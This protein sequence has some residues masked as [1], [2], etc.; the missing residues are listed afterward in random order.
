MHYKGKAAGYDTTV[1][2]FL[3]RD[4]T[5][6]PSSLLRCLSGITPDCFVRAMSAPD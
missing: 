2:P 5:G 1:A 4:I 6:R 3:L